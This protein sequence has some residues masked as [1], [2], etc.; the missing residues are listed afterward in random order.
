MGKKTLTII[1]SVFFI[2][3]M[4]LPGPAGRSA[5][6]GRPD[7]V[8]TNFWIWPKK[9]T[10]REWFDIRVRVRNNSDTDLTKQ[11][12]VNIFVGGST[13]PY[14]KILYP[15]GAKQDKDFEQ[16]IFL[17]LPRKYTARA[18]VD[19]D[20]KIME[21]REDNNTKKLDFTIKK[22][23]SNEY[24]PELSIYKPHFSPDKP[25][26]D[27]QIEFRVSI[28]NN[29]AIRSPASKGAIRVGGGKLVLLDFP[30]I[31]PGESKTVTL[32]RQLPTAGK[33][34]VTAYADYG[35]RIKEYDEGNNTKFENFE[36]YGN[37]C[38]DLVLSD[39]YVW[40]WPKHP[41]AG[42]KFT[43]RVRVFNRGLKANP[44]PAKLQMFV[45]G[46]ST[47]YVFNVYSIAPGDEKT[48]DKEISFGRPGNYVSRAVVDPDNQVKECKEDNNKGQVR[49]KIGKP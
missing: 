12:T 26:T 34:R 35:N 10:S 4:F 17:D 5:E 14:T 6:A 23:K 33:Y 39:N 22:A 27:D 13:A 37:C 9:P 18:I 16:R 48:Y 25:C 19:P 8:I 41:K 40:I 29:G 38:P 20:N 42:E 32:A 49:F 11:T 36:V 1:G 3:A 44:V 7:L 46:G 21:S 2:L 31:E 15:L 30:P 45:G 24:L 47:P 28:I 43:L